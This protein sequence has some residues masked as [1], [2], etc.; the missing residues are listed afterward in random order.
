MAYAP[1][2]RGAFVSS[3]VAG[4]VVS[5]ACACGDSQPPPKTPQKDEGVP[6][7][8]LSDARLHG[9]PQKDDTTSPPPA[10]ESKADPTQPYVTKVGD[11]PPPESTSGKKPTGK[12]GDS[13][14]KGA[15]SKGECDRAM[16]KYLQLEIAQNP[17][18]KDVPPEVIEQAKQMAREKHGEAPCTA[19]RAQYNCAVAATSTAAWQ[20]CM[21]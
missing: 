19:T 10:S 21:K 16:E 15:V 8:S 17:Q 9:E 4:L 12:S 3:L 11:A 20:R 13:G 6:A 1:L 14:G 5:F 7:N 18:L 2:V